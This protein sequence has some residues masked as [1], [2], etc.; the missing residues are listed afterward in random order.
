V[1]LRARDVF[2]VHRVHHAAFDAH[3]DGLVAGI[4]DDGALKYPFRHFSIRLLRRPRESGGPGQARKRRP[5]IPA[6]AGMTKNG[7]D[8]ALSGY[9]LA[10]ARCRS[11]ST[12]LMRAISRRAW[13]TRAVF[14]S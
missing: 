2:L 1:F 6:C 4:A 10:S 14:S 5:W 11:P 13:R 3:D 9:A 12:V 8:T 7:E